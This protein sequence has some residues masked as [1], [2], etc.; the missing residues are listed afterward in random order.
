MSSCNK[1]RG[2]NGNPAPHPDEVCDWKYVTMQALDRDVSV[3]PEAYTEWFKIILN[4]IQNKKMD[5]VQ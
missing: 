4:E 1:V 2:F 3:R 5:I